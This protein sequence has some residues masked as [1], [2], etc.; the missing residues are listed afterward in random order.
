MQRSEIPVHRYHFISANSVEIRPPPLFDGSRTRVKLDFGDSATLDLSN[1]IYMLAVEKL[2]IRVQ[3]PPNS[4]MFALRI[5]NTGF[6]STRCT[7]DNLV[8]CPTVLCGP[9]GIHLQN[10]T[11][12]YMGT[13][14]S[15]PNFLNSYVDL[16]IV[17]GAT[18]EALAVNAVNYFS[19]TFVVYRYI[20]S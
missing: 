5:G 1:N 11:R 9:E 18:G 6:S 17:D 7:G 12:S 4:N 10:V 16:Q 2:L 13:V 14:I 20:P 19:G 8:Q 15:N 3:T